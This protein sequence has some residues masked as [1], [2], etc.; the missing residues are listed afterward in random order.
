MLS[1]LKAASHNA[2]LCLEGEGWE[3]TAQTGEEEQS[4]F[5]GNSYLFKEVPCKQSGRAGAGDCG[6]IWPTILASPFVEYKQSLFLSFSPFL[7]SSLPPEGRP[8][9]SRITAAELF[10]AKEGVIR[11]GSE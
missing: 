9:C 8:L 1:V 4:S 7:A 6:C 11:S 3:L 10:A 5:L 2:N